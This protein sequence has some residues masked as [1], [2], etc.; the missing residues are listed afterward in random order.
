[1]LERCKSVI[2]LLQHVLSKIVGSSARG[3]HI[4]VLFKL[5]FL[6]LNCAKTEHLI[7]KFRKLYRVNTTIHSMFWL[8][9]ELCMQ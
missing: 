1:M 2:V 6:W 8:V 4:W 3:Y 5:L 7:M 9:N